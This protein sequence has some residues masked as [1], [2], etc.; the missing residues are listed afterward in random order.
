MLLGLFVVITKQIFPSQVCS[1]QKNEAN[2]NEKYFRH[3]EVGGVQ[4]RKHHIY[5]E[6]TKHSAK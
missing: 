1:K 2:T 5:S 6:H 3:F 4:T